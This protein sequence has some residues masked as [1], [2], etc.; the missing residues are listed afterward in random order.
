MADFN[1]S[2]FLAELR[3]R[4]FFLFLNPEFLGALSRFFI[5]TKSEEELAQEEQQKQRLEETVGPTTE[6]QKTQTQQQQQQ[7]QQ[8]QPTREGKLLLVLFVGHD[9]YSVSFLQDLHKARC[10]SIYSLKI[11]K[12][13]WW[14]TQRTRTIPKLSS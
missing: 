5:V 2:L 4:P 12:W 14:R 6:E 13:Y 9:S 1:C 3:L 8:E 10:K 7:Q 11:Q